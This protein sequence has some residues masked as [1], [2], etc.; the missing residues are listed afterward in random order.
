MANAIR[1]FRPCNIFHVKRKYFWQYDNSEW[2]VTTD[3]QLHTLRY[4]SELR[5]VTV[6]FLCFLVPY[7]VFISSTEVQNL[8]Q[9][10]PECW[11]VQVVCSRCWSPNKCVAV[12]RVQNNIGHDTPAPS[13]GSAF[14]PKQTL[15]LVVPPTCLP[16][17]PI[18][19]QDPAVVLDGATHVS[20]LKLPCNYVQQ[21]PVLWLSGWWSFRATLH[22]I[23]HPINF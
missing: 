10:W 21:M 17:P 18:R 14:P 13:H 3:R 8:E 2:S 1:G 19:S 9:L 11:G 5:I 12:C 6:P 7:C 15:P 4:I 23:L 20:G 22:L 16:P